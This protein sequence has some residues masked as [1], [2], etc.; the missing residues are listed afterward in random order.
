MNLSVPELLFAFKGRIGR[1]SFAVVFVGQL[2]FNLVY[3][4]LF[5][6][7][8]T[9]LG[10]AAPTGAPP[11]L[12]ALRTSLSAS[13][14]M[15]AIGVVSLWISL[16]IQAK[17]LHDFGWSGWWQGAPAAVGLGCGVAC[18]L[19]TVA[20]FK[21]AGVLLA[22]LGVAA[23]GLGGLGLLGIM[24]F[25]KGDPGENA[26]DGEEP[27]ERPR[28]QEAAASVRVEA[29]ETAAPAAQAVARAAAPKRVGVADEILLMTYRPPQDRRATFGRR[30]AA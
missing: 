20:G 15:M 14:L 29:R 3:S 19:L 12:D 13:L 22:L 17:R 6:P 5:M 27:D 11:S 21:A 9:A 8:L 4:A 25:R 7:K 24:L 26:F 2:I 18:G 10:L 28:P 23:A 1:G 30:T 16:A